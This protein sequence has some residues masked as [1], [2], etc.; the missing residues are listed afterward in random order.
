M[1]SFSTLLQLTDTHLGEAEDFRLWGLAADELL[2]RVLADAHARFPRLDLVVHTGDATHDAGSPAQR[3]IEGLLAGWGAPVLWAPGNHDLPEV[4]AGQ[5]VS[6]DL[7]GWRVLLINSRKPGAVE[8]RV[9]DATLAWLDRELGAADAPVLLGLHHPPLPT[10]TP[11]LDRIGLENADAL[12]RVIR[13]HARVRAIIHGHAHMEQT[14]LHEGVLVLG[15]PSTNGQ[16]RPL[17]VGF[18][19]DGQPPGYRWLRLY[20]DGRLESGVVRVGG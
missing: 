8:G 13:R 11:W 10:G 1:N 6:F 17:S 15:T 20:R 4:M 9:D 3:R 7:P 19:L 16:F 14:T 18:A 2:R 12:W 5:P